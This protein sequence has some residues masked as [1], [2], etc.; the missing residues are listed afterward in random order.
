MINRSFVEQVERILV[1][2][3][4]LRMVTD[5]LPYFE[6]MCRLVDNPALWEPAP[7]D[8]G[9]CLPQTEFARKSELNGRAIHRIAVRR[10]PVIG[11]G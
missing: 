6:D 9:R 4:V 3:G 10:R 8:D 1:E 2:H 11:A 5:D 7:W